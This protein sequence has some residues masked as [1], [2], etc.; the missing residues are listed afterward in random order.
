[1]AE[2]ILTTVNYVTVITS[3]LVVTIKITE[4]DWR[5]VVNQ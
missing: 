4:Y 1:M 5:N 3:L 2:T